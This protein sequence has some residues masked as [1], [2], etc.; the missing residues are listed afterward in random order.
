MHIGFMKGASVGGFGEMAEQLAFDLHGWFKV[1]FCC[2]V[3]V[4]PVDFAMECVCLHFFD[5]V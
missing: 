4:Q 3:I 5:L 1:Y 2:S